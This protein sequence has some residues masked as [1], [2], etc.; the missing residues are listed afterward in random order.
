ME[1]GKTIREQNDTVVDDV[2][3][4]TSNEARVAKKL[5]LAATVLGFVS[6][7]LPWWTFMMFTGGRLSAYF[8]FFLFG[9]LKQGFMKADYRLEWWSY[10]TLTLV[11]LGT[12]LGTVGHRFLAKQRKN[13]K[14]LVIGGILFTVS[15]CLVYSVSLTYVFGNTYWD[16]NHGWI[17]ADNAFLFARLNPFI[18][19]TL[20]IASTEIVVF[21]FLSIGFFAAAFSAL[22]SIAA[23][24]IL[25]HPGKKHPS[26]TRALN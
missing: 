8:H 5:L 3:M 10:A 18:I 7:A 24:H 14:E 12:I 21:E 16:I 26:S 1:I 13:W 15:G 25:R 19:H 9:F 4:A 2:I 22:L 17:T 20:N 6:L 11:G 23:L